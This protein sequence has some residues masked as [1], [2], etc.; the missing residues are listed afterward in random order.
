MEFW[1]I[2]WLWAHCQV[3]V[4]IFWCDLVGNWSQG[5]VFVGLDWIGMIGIVECPFTVPFPFY[6]AAIRKSFKCITCTNWIQRWCFVW[7]D[8]LSFKWYHYCTLMQKKRDGSILGLLF[9]CPCFHGHIF[10][11]NWSE[12]GNLVIPS[13]RTPTDEPASCLFED[14]MK[15]I[16]LHLPGSS[17]LYL[18]LHSSYEIR[19]VHFILKHDDWS[20]IDPDLWTC[21]CVKM[22]TLVSTYVV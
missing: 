9:I 21:P 8:V 6:D 4:C 22:N 19:W 12:A 16:N 17:E 1:A 2:E 20:D 15:S 7:S 11:K 13:R 5:T 3:M 10:I 14:G 18:I